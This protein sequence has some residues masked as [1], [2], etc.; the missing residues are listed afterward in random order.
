MFDYA[1]LTRLLEIGISP[2]SDK[3]LYVCDDKK[4][5][6]RFKRHNNTEGHYV[7]TIDDVWNSN[8]LVGKRYKAYKIIH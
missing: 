7:F 4:V 6:N 1:M 5:L 2:Y 3:M 8:V